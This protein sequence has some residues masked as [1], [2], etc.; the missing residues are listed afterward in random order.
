MGWL[1]PDIFGIMDTSQLS[2]I[3]SKARTIFFG[4]DS[5]SYHVNKGLRLKFTQRLATQ[6][7][8]LSVPF[9]EDFPS[10]LK[11]TDHVVDA[12]FGSSAHSVVLGRFTDCCQ[13]SPSQARSANHFPQLSQPL[14]QQR[15]R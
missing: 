7:K 9:T 14:K 4:Q 5:S 3:Q 8:D 13:A 6:L 12:I 2:T 11:E 10:A 1:L 15:F